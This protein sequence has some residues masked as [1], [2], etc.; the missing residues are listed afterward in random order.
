[1]FVVRTFIRK[2]IAVQ[3][4]KYT[5]WWRNPDKQDKWNVYQS[6]LSK[7]KAER[8]SKDITY[9]LSVRWFDRNIPT[10]ILTDGAI[11]DS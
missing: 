11:I 5:I 9:F 6:G 4:L 2:K 10:R 1:L 7:T 3:K 8:L